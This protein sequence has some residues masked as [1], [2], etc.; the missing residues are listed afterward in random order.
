MSLVFRQWKIYI[1]GNC[2]SG[3]PLIGARG[4]KFSYQTIYH[5]WSNRAVRERVR[6]EKCACT[7]ARLL[8]EEQRTH[9]YNEW[10][11]PRSHLVINVR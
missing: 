1:G 6:R 7:Y 8:A 3:H 5:G 11:D 9:Y 2:G 10:K 4:S